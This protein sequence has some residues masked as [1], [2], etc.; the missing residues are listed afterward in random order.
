MEGVGKIDIE[1]RNL[2][3][4]LTHE[5]FNWLRLQLWTWWP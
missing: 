5:M 3:W 4:I 1:E 2:F